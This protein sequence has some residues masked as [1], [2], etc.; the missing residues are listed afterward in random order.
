MRHESGRVVAPVRRAK[1]NNGITRKC[2]LNERVFCSLRCVKGAR[3]CRLAQEIGVSKPASDRLR[4]QGREIQ[5]TARAARFY[6]PTAVGS[7]PATFF[8]LPSF[9]LL[10]R[11][12]EVCNKTSA[13]GSGW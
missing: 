12:T 1:E 7:G 2:Y 5:K 9:D 13:W 4:A 3:V 11:K 6:F 8:S 10:W